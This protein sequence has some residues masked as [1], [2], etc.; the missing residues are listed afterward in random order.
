MAAA[1]SR[2]IGAR[3]KTTVMEEPSVTI[4]SQAFTRICNAILALALIAA[5]LAG[6]GCA[7]DDDEDLVP[8][9]FYPDAVL[10]VLDL[11]IVPYDYAGIELPAHFQRPE[12][13]ALDN[14][15]ADNPLS[16]DGATLGRVLFY[17]RHLSANDTIAC[18]SCHRQENGF[19]DPAEFSEGFE[20]GLTGRNSM[21]LANSRFYENGRFFWDERAATLEDQVLMPIQDQVEMGLT[22]DELVAKVAAQPYYPPLFQRAFGDPE[23]TSER[24]AAALAQFVRSMVSY[25]SRFDEGLAQVGDIAVA[26]PNFTDAEN[27]GKSLFLDER[28]GCAAC[29]LGNPPPPP[30]GPDRPLANQA[31]FFVLGPVNNGLDSDAVATDPG[32]GGHTGDPDDQAAFKSSSLRNIELTAPYMHDG[33]HTDLVKVIEFYSFGVQPHSNLDRRLRLPG[34]SEPRRLNLDNGEIA[35]LVAFLRTLTDGPFISDPIYADPFRSQ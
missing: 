32:V 12:V 34:S 17:D 1:M 20:G 24:I 25:R 11:P 26:F 22:L 21:S 28:G 31:V 10:S 13:L 3:D 23:V 14:T 6:A 18:A 2:R 16:N 19:S 9:Q 29:H 5:G 4:S 7:P 35:A 15:P 30:G 33:R 8:G 27:L